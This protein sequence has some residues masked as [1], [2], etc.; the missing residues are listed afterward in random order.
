M[1]AA[2]Q[3]EWCCSF[4]STAAELAPVPQTRQRLQKPEEEADGRDTAS[5]LD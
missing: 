3:G 5:P 1:P 2:Q 4:P